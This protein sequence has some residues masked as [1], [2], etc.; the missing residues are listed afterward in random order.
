MKVTV[1]VCDEVLSSTLV[2]SAPKL[3]IDGFWSSVL[4]IETV[5]VWVAL[6]PAASVAVAVSVSLLFPKL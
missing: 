4:L 3:P 1:C 2:S 5:I 6:L